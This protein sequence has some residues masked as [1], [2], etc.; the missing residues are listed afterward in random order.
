MPNVTAE[1]FAALAV[2]ENGDPVNPVVYN[3]FKAIVTAMLLN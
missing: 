1:L 3:N 2:D